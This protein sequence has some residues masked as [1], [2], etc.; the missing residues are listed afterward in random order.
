LRSSFGLQLV[1][2]F[3]ALVKLLTYEKID[4]ITRKHFG[5]QTNEE[6]KLGI[7]ST[8]AKAA[9]KFSSEAWVLKKKDYKKWKLQE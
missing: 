4:G 9:L 7:R 3:P 6:T 1:K 5:T 2:K 8:T